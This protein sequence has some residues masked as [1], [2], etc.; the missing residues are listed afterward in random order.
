MKKAILLLLITAFVWMSSCGGDDDGGAQTV[1]YTGKEG[2]TTYTLKFTEA[3]ARYAAQTGDSYELTESSTRRTSRG[4]AA[5]ISGSALTLKP[6]NSNVTFTATVSDDGLTGLNGTVTWTNRTTTVFGLTA[7]TPTGTSSS[8]GGV[9]SNWKW[10]A[11]ADSAIWEYTDNRG[12]IKTASI[13]A[14]A[15]GNGRWVA[16]GEQGKMAYSTNG[17]SWTAVAD[18][19]FGANKYDINAIAY[20]SAGNAGGRFVAVGDSGRIAYSDDGETWET[21]ADSTFGTY[22]FGLGAIDIESIAFGNNRFVAGGYQGTMAYSDDGASW[23]AVADSTF[24]HGYPVRAIAY[25]NGTWVAVSGRILEDKDDD[26][27]SKMAYSKDNGVTWTAIAKGTAFQYTGTIN[28]RT[29]TVVGDIGSIA[30]GSVGNAGGRFVAGSGY[31]TIAYSTDGINWTGVYNVLGT[32]TQKLSGNTMTAGKMVGAI[33]YG[34]GRFVGISFVVDSV[35]MPTTWIIAYS[36]DG[37]S[38]TTAANSTF[39]FLDTASVGVI[40]YG[41]GRFVAVGRQGGMAYADWGEPDSNEDG[42][43]Y[44]EGSDDG[45]GGYGYILP[46]PRPPIAGDSG[47]MAYTD[48]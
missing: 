13:K 46:P 37:I 19:I 47:K 40:A 30:Y 4:T 16:G 41:N 24:G 38:W 22:G 32:Y 12:N 44:G 5:N 43:I 31:G 6:S 29:D 18:S 42:G 23:T 11:A 21:V 36:A 39:T 7:L 15:Y 26:R 8:G 9:D 45:G 35:G 10:T 2:N 33:A 25:G 3:A 14:I 48:W 1:T 27:A 17:T 20:G 34:N 28:G